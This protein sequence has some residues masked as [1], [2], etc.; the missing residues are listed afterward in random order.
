MTENVDHSKN[1][2]AVLSFCSGYGGLERGLELA[3]FEHRVIAYVEIEAFAIALLV[4]KMEE[5]KV[6]AAPV[7]TDIKTF[8]SEIF[9]DKVSLI[10]GGYPCQPFSSA[11]KKKGDKDPRH[12]WPYIRRHIKSIRPIQC[13]FENV[14]GHIALG[15]LSVV[16]EL[17]SML[18]LIHISEPTR[19]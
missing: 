19:R 7:Y 12:L 10:I 11:G 5:G 17:E 14:Q 4:K 18:S 15:L 3:G 16:S 2:P 9:R 6:P 8:P 1:T 13:L